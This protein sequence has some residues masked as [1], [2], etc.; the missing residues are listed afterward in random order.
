V[1]L[2]DEDLARR[3]GPAGPRKSVAVT[4]LGVIT[5]LLGGAAVALGGFGVVAWLTTLAPWRGAFLVAG[6]PALLLGVLALVAGLGA[7]LRKQWGRI[8][9]LVLAGLS[10]LSALLHLLSLLSLSLS[11]GPSQLSVLLPHFLLAVGAALPGVLAFVILIR[12]GAEFSCLQG[13]SK[14]E[15]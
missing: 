8:L 13:P 2:D 10:L 1:P 6:V 12:N 9:T 11:A 7:L 4:V 5:L 14:D 15:E 3:I